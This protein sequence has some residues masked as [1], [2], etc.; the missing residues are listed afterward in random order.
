MQHLSLKSLHCAI[1]LLFYSI[2][3]NA[4]PILEL[5][6][7]NTAPFTSVVSIT[8]CGDER[9]FVV[10]QP[11]RIFIMNKNGQRISPAFLDISGRVQSGGE[12]GLLGLA[13]HPNYAE[14]GQFFVNYTRTG[15]GAT[16]VSRFK[17][18]PANPNRALAGSEEVLFTVNQPFTNHNGG[19]LRFGPDGMLYIGLG[20]GGSGGDPQNLSQNRQTL[21]GKLLRID[22]SSQETGYTTPP[23]NPFA[24]NDETLDE[25]WALGL[26]NPWRFSFDKATGDMWIADV[27]QNALEEINFAPASSTGG[28]NYGWRCYEGTRAF[29]TNGCGDAGQYVFPIFE[30]THNQGDRSVTGGFV[31]RGAAFPALQG[32]YF[33]AD[34]VS[35]RFFRLRRSESEVESE[36]IGTLGLPSPSTFGEDN[37]GEL[38]VASYFN[39]FVYQMTDFCQAFFPTLSFETDQN[40]QIKV[41]LENGVWPE[42]IQVE[43]YLDDELLATNQDSVFLFAGN[44]VY[45]AVITHSRGCSLTSEPLEVIHVGTESTALPLDIIITPNPFSDLIRIEHQERALSAI[46][47][48]NTQGKPIIHQNIKG[49]GITNLQLSSLPAGIYFVQITSDTGVRWLSKII[50]Q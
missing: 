1:T 13:F 43:W 11:G 9:L 8:H 2:L 49:K 29:N 31:Y 19:D 47:I 24:D 26:R 21:L 16:V 36:V 46:T 28:E 34:F 18:D 10:E 37:N 14:N 35:S 20:D 22:V 32:N 44:G 45:Q 17:V 5:R 40:L 15:G 39:G 38:Y 42:D 23:S 41:R 7:V 30:Y 33:F 25:I 50:K 6:Q 27:G 3:S 12:R 4:Q 48:I